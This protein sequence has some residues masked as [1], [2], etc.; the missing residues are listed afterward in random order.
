MWPVLL[1]LDLPS[2]TVRNHHHLH[3]SHCHNPRGKL[4]P[5][6]WKLPLSLAA[7][8]LKGGLYNQEEEMES[9]KCK[10]EGETCPCADL[11]ARWGL[12]ISRVLVTGSEMKAAGM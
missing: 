5:R 4:R 1:Y 8:E 12:R 11:P 6:A 3:H 7:V 10:D 2:G 9:L